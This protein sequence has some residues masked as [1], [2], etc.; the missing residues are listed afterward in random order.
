MIHTSAFASDLLSYAK[1]ARVRILIIDDESLDLF[2]TRTV[3]QPEFEVEAFSSLDDAVNWA[4]HHE[5]DAALIDYYLGSDLSASD[6]L[7][8][9]QR[10]IPYPIRNAFVL[11]NFLD[12]HQIARLKSAG[13]EGIIMKPV[14][15]ELVRSHLALVK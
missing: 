15:L 11:S 14:T 6:A 5:F 10:V 7:N 12:A 1:F 3:L 8:A 4:S 13:F 2:I 9:L